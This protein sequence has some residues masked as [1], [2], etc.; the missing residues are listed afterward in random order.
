MSPH[1]KP[2]DF[3]T[4][5]N[6]TYTALMWAMSRPGLPR[7]MP[8][9][10]QAPIIETLIDRE[11]SVYCETPELTNIARRTGAALIDACQADHLFFERL[12]NA[13]LLRGVRSG[14]DL[15][16]EDGATLVLG[17]DFGQGQNL[18][19]SGP[20]VDGAVDVVIGGVP[21]DLWAIRDQTMRYPMGF[22]IFL[23]DGAQIIGLP[24]SVNVEVL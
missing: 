18:R 14:S 13:A 4:R 19:L 15:H 12:E 24:R 9:S 6:A 8:Q 17:A 23:V 11:C 2:S 22:D 5:C 21:T 10:G 3:E 20:G 7:D 1:P 16:P